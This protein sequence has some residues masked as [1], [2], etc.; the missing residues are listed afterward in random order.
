MRHQS[1]PVTLSTEEAASWIMQ[2]KIDQI[3]HRKETLLTPE[4]IKELEH[5]SSL[6]SS[7][8]Y[9]LKDLE[10]LFKE[11]IKNGTPIENSDELEGPV[12]LPFDITIP[13]TKGLKELE[14]NRKYANDLLK[15]GKEVEN[16]TIYL[17][18]DPENGMV[19]GMDIE[20][21]EMPDYTREMTSLESDTSGKLFRKDEDTVTMFP[22]RKK[23]DEGEDAPEEEGG[24]EAAVQEKST[25][26]EKFI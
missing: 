16:T 14:A 24:Q 13:P 10:K 17:I 25:E 18:P 3:I 8:I 20:G 4:K 23:E 26:D 2:H 5:K 7:A 6:A 15:A 22:D 11:K 9:T 1:I 12:R 21:T 19:I